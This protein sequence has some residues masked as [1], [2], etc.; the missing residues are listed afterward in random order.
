MARSH[1]LYHCLRSLPRRDHLKTNVLLNRKS[2]VIGNFTYID[3]EEVQN[4]ELY[5][6]LFKYLQQWYERKS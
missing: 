5:W 3:R 2:V 6:I 1:N 4:K